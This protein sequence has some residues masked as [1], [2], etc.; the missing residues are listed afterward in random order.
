M[1]INLMAG[2]RAMFARGD[3]S[4]REALFADL[5]DSLGGKPVTESQAMSIPA[6]NLAVNII[7]E[8]ISM[9][10]L[11][12][13]RRD[14]AVVETVE[15]HP[16]YDVYSNPCGAQRP[17]FTGQM[18]MKGILHATTIHGNAYL[19]QV[20][21]DGGRKLKYLKPIDPCRVSLEIINDKPVY[22]IAPRAH[23]AE[24]QRSMI[25]R[26][27]MPPDIIHIRGRYMDAEG[28]FGVSTIHIMR[29][30]LN[31]C[32]AQNR[33]ARDSLIGGNLKGFIS[34]DAGVFGENTLTNISKIFN[35]PGWDNRIPVITE[36]MKFTPYTKDNVSQ[37]FDQSRSAQVIEIGRMFNI[38]PHLMAHTAGISNWGSGLTQMGRA[39]VQYSLSPWAERI[40]DALGASLLT[41]DER[42]RGMYF[43]FDFTR[44][45]RGNDME[46]AQVAQIH[47]ASGVK[48]PCDVRKDEGL[49]PADGCDSD[50]KPVG[51]VSAPNGAPPAGMRPP[52]EPDEPKE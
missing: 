19:E 49:P 29:N 41:E 24:K 33:H 22:K 40:E 20:R 17:G 47:I 11:R 25:E 18:M 52:N 46:R 44:L 14:G 34:P 31:I 8:S 7:G 4:V 9:L 10:P 42:A 5:V 37:Q 12:L 6:F 50:Y 51:A 15:S 13:K 28:W 30:T 1:K 32:L 38:P 43:E 23:S 35:S 45:L 48:S 39:F 21:V 16:F 26:T 27:L 2:V 3:T 36:A